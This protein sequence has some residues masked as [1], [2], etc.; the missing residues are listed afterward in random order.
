ME[1][2][3]KMNKRARR[4]RVGIMGGTFDPIH[5]GHLVAADEAYQAFNLDQVLFVPTGHPPHKADMSVTSAEDRF[6]MT[7][8]ATI[9]CP[10]FELSRIEIDRVGNSYTIDTIK[11]LKAMEQYRDS[12]FYF[13]TGLDAVMQ[14][15]TWKHPEELMELCRFVAVSRYGYTHDKMRDLPAEMRSAIIPLEIPLIAISST[16]IRRRVSNGCS[17]RYL[18][19]APVEC[20]IR[21]R[22]LYKPKKPLSEE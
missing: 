6:T 2:D 17:I 5:Y 22:G 1:R 4:K 10:Y 12:D 15:V 7:T 13:I 21:K 11:E 16:E 8:L 20:F 3:L 9:N 19:P 18:V 14:I